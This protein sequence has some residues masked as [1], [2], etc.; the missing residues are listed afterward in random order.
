M[1]SPKN[2]AILV[3]TLVVL[4]GLGFFLLNKAK[5]ADIAKQVKDE[6]SKT[7]T[8]QKASESTESK[9]LNETKT[10]LEVDSKK[11][12]PTDSKQDIDQELNSLDKI[13][14]DANPDDFGEDK[15]SD[16]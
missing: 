13:I 15:L 3:I 4:V 1:N 7:V 16:L 2:I 10:E 11:S 9:S 12:I 5:N 8:E 14:K 6:E